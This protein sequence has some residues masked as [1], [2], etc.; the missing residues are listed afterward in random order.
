[1]I[2]NANKNE[3]ELIQNA[4]DEKETD[5]LKTEDAADIKASET[6]NNENSADEEINADEAE[7]NEDK[8][9]NKGKSNSFFASL[10]GIAID[11]IVV[12]GISAALLYISNF[13]MQFLGYYISAKLDMLFVLF[14]ILNIIYTAI[15][16]ASKFSGTL[17]KL[18]ANLKV[19]KLGE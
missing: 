15:M 8:V 1:M 14:L 2:E 6:E 16:E 5:T 7:S 11:E 18:V 9:T 19:R 13:V 17:G 12:L 10:L 4:S 3:E